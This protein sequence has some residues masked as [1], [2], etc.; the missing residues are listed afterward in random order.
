MKNPTYSF[1][2]A[3]EQQIKDHFWRVD[4]DFSPPLHTYVDISIYAEKLATSSVRLE[5]F[6]EANL[7]GLI[8]GYYN[9]DKQFLFGSNFSI[10]KEYRGKGMEL[11]NVLLIFMGNNQEQFNLSPEM[12]EIGIQFLEALKEDAKPAKLVMKS[13]HTEVHHSN[14]RLI[15][16]Y[17]RLGFKEVETTNESIYLIKEI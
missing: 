10:E 8:A 9:S 17:K 16:Y 7:I 1:N 6:I 12:K 5:I 15:L 4:A 14:R 11:F 3:T 2:K 13:I